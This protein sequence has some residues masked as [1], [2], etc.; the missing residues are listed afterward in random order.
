MQAVDVDRGGFQ[1]AALVQL[2][3][4]GPC[5]VI[6]SWS[7]AG[8]WAG[9]GWVCRWFCQG[10]AKQDVFPQH[11]LVLFDPEHPRPSLLGRP[12]RKG[13][14]ECVAAGRLDGSGGLP[15]GRAR[16]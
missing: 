7:P 9:E 5:M 6:D 15:R 13:P 16:L 1:P 2:L 4:G 14:V 3:A 12:R 8:S 11:L 10:S